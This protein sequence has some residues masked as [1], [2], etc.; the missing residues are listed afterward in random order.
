MRTGG[1]QNKH[2]ES[3]DQ[4]SRKYH[5][6]PSLLMNI[7]GGQKREIG[8][9]FNIGELEGVDDSCPYLLISNI[10]VCV[11]TDGGIFVDQTT[12]KRLIKPL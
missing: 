10:N 11:H 6:S 9:I 12:P 2:L 8:T 1:G 3:T 7:I 4:S 5:I